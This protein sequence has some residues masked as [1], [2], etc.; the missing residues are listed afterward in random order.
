MA[1]TSYPLN[2]I[3]VVLLENIHQRAVHAFRDAGFNVEHHRVAYQGDALLEVAGDAHIIGLRSKS[4]LTE[5]FFASARRLWGVGCFCIG[6]N[7]VDLPAA[8]ARGVPVFNEAF[9][10]TRSVAELVISEI[11]ALHRQLFDRSQA[12]HEGR[13]RKSAEGAHEIRGRRLGIVGYGRIG[14][15]VSV[16]AEAM[17][18]KVSFYDIRSVLPMGNAERHESLES[19]LRESDVVTLHVPATPET[20][21]MIGAAELDLMK[22]SAYLLNNARGNVVDIDALAERL[23][24]EKIAGAAVDVFPKEPSSNQEPFSSPLQGL[25]NVILSPHIG[26]STLEAQEA[27][28]ESVSSRLIRFM[29]NGDS[30]SAVNIPQVQLPRLHPEH[31][32]ILHFHQNVP[33]VLGKMHSATARLGVNIAAQQLQSDGQYAYAIMDVSAHESDALKD[34]LAAIP[35]TIRIRSLW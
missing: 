13:W 14:S 22:P 25:K 9:S 16:L 19:L 34:E 28:A 24:A 15:Q 33:G 11:V 20:A 21:G 18:M 7:Q 10:N 17:G 23:R 12:M 35:E 4:V 26:G 1:N 3:K 32:R 31:H 30:D 6:T 5:E 29:N 27:I 8:A 2:E